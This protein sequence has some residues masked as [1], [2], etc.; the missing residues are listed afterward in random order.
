MASEL[1]FPEEHMSTRH[2]YL[3]RPW[4]SPAPPP[5]AFSGHNTQRHFLSRA[6]PGQARQRGRDDPPS[7]AVPA[8]P[9]ASPW[10]RQSD[11]L[12]IL[13][14]ILAWLKRA[15]EHDRRVLWRGI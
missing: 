10:P 15:L 14:A 7:L 5:Q 3:H 11:S 8:K 13:K 12:R 6:T 4:S 2:E 1:G 9:L